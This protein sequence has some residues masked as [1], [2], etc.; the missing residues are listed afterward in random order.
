VS[1]RKR[2]TAAEWARRIDE[3]SRSGLDADT[4]AARD[5][6]AYTTRTLCWWKSEL[7]RRARADRRR[8]AASTP[9]TLMPVEVRKSATPSDLHVAPLEVVIG[10]RVVVRVPAAA[11]VHRV[12]ELVAALEARRP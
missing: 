7:K 11:D 12:A 8:S 10:A 6:G 9:V 5:G 3:W 1:D 4:F 2:S